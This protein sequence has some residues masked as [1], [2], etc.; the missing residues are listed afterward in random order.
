ME[1]REVHNIWYKRGRF[2][3]CAWVL[4]LTSF[5]YAQ[6]PVKSYTIKNGKMY[7][8]LGKNLEKNSLDSF[9]AK[10][11]LYDLDLR[12]FVKKGK[13]D[14]LTKMGWK[15]DV[16]NN[17]LFIISKP[18]MGFDN[19]TDP[20]DK[21]LMTQKENFSARFPVTSNQVHF[22]YNRFKTKYPFAVSGDVV[23]FFLRGN[24]KAGRV[25][26]AGS[27]NNWQPQALPMI[28]TDSGWIAKVKLAVGKYWY[29]FVIDGGWRIDMDNIRMENDGLG[30]DNSVYFKTNY[31]FKLDGYPNAKKVY[32]AGSF[33]NW[34]KNDLFMQRTAK[35]WAIP[36]YLSE[37]THTYRFIVDGN[38]LIDPANPDKLAN[39]YNDFNS[40]LRLGTPYEFKLDG[41]SDAKKVVL[42]GSFN[43][44]NDNE[45]F[46]IK[47]ATG[48]RLPYTLG[49]GN[50]QYNLK[51]DGKQAVDARSK[52]NIALVIAPN[53]TFRI[54]GFA[55]AKTVCLAGALNDWNPTSFRM[56]RVGDE[57]IFKAHLN[58]GKHPYKFVVDGKWMRDPGNKLWEQNEYNTGNSIVWINN[59]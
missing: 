28:Q 52:G 5:V 20:A 46:M 26:L 36:V 17:E 41:Y 10:Y 50:Y 33:N 15:I 47:T 27:F 4:L 9:I 1:M 44:W 49:P 53:F 18:L 7:I 3:L 21:I 45:L 38:W 16:N 23:T 8:A 35:G 58:A 22:G 51:I 40:V 6:P 2:Y 29:K 12:N 54:K 59:D 39:E 13:P 55:D 11:D 37:G 56:T 42:L 30:N 31:V 14:S 19:F 48:W 25:M 43:N 34:K 32:L 24:T 57:W